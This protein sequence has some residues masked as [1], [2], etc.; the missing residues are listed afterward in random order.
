MKGL[1][2]ESRSDFHLPKGKGE[3]AARA[4]IESLTN[5]VAKL[6]AKTEEADRMASDYQSKVSE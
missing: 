2:E 3:E 1:M 5:Q 6:A 4:E